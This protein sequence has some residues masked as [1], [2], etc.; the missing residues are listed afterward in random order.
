MQLRHIYKGHDIP[1]LTFRWRSG[2]FFEIR[3]FHWI[4]IFGAAGIQITD[5]RVKGLVHENP[6]F[7]AVC[8]SAA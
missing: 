6:V 3:V 1:G 4:F 5:I 7:Y 2:C 8:E